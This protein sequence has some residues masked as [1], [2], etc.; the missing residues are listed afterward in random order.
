MSEK[1]DANVTL[2]PEKKPFR[3]AGLMELPKHL[4][5]SALCA[6]ILIVGAFFRRRH[7]AFQQRAPDIP[8]SDACRMRMHI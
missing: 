6:V 2:M 8:F 1:G 4:V 7:C 5:L 3:F